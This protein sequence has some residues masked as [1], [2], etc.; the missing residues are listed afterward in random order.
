MKKIA[1]QVFRQILPFAALLV[2]FSVA[3]PA[4]SDEKPAP[5]APQKREGWSFTEAGLIPLQS[6][7][8]LKPLD[9]FAREIVLFETGSRVFQGWDPV[10][11]IISW[12]T[13]AQAWDQV[14]FLQISRADVKRQLGLEEKRS[15]FSPQELYKNMA[16]AQYASRMPPEGTKLTDREQELKRVLDRLGLFRSVVSGDAWTVVPTD[17]TQ[18]WKNL[19]NIDPQTASANDQLIRNSF[20]ELFHS[21]QDG[22]G[23]TFARASTRT[24]AAVEGDIP[25]WN[26]R[27]AK[28]IVAESFY[29]RT[30]PFLIA[31][32][33]YLLSAVLWIITS[34]R[35]KLRRG[36]AWL[37]LSIA[38]GAHILGFALRCYVAGRPPVT[39]MYESIV[40]VSFGVVVFALVLY[41][42]QRQAIALIVACTLA[43]FGL[44]AGDA[45]PAMLDPGLHPLVPVL[46]SNYWLTVHVLTITLGYAAFALSFGL[47]DVVLFKYLKRALKREGGATPSSIVSLNQLTY[48]SMQFGVVLLAAGTILGGIWADYSWG[49]FW[50][51]DPKEVW[52]LIALLCYLVILHGRYAGWVAQFSFSV[53]TVASFLSVIMA[54]YGVNFV[55]G[56]GLH[57][58]GF[59]SGGRGWVAAFVG[60]QMLYVLAVVLVHRLNER[61]V[62]T[63]AS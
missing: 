26:E 62:N 3:S 15:R 24:K 10:E 28:A 21:Y 29:N 5:V 43:A 9:S 56:V 11:M 27:E 54:W 18:S 38:L 8:R 35:S 30:R 23:A 14:Q 57:S 45:A 53:W 52:A 33:F 25:G 7:G 6:S 19:A 37:S 4:L 20:V 2:S 1:R 17:P 47:G 49:R 58:Y 16:L 31:W 44:I 41:A 36:V 46:R 39:N 63:S 32:I 60:L 48:R 12:M 61:R 40:W 13:H 50:G 55:L 51:W 34:Q 42:I 22:D 59:S